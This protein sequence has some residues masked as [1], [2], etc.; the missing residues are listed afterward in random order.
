MSAK[1]PKA[2][3]LSSA[4]WF[5]KASAGVIAGFMLTLAICGLLAHF[6]PLDV[7][8]FSA[9]SQIS[10]WLMSPVWGLIMSFCFLFR[11]GVHAWAWLGSANAVL[12]GLLLGSQYLVGQ[13]G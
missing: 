9:Q 12:W 1:L 3:Q 10:M 13:G 2:Q 4:N 6:G 7:G 11:N 8:Y 5:G